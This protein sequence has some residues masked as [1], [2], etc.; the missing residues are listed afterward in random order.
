M[1]C[2]RYPVFQPLARVERLKSSGRHPDSAERRCHFLL[3][4]IKLAASTSWSPP[5]RIGSQDN[6]IYQ[7]LIRY[8]TAIGPDG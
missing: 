5:G 2:R 7:I 4:M 3:A 8:R 1:D 6:P